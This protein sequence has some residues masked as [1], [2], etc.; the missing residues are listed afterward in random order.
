MASY[1][2]IVNPFDGKMTLVRADSAFHLKDSVDT[3]YDLPIINN[4]END[5]RIT[6]DTDLM[7]TW[8][9]AS[10]SGLIADWKQIGSASSVDWSAITN[11][12]SSSVVN[13]D[14]AVDKKHSHSNKTELDKVSDGDH[15]IRTDNPHEVDKSDVGLDNVDNKSEATI[16]TNVKADS[17]VSDAISKKHSQNT[18]TNIILTEVPADVSASGIKTTFTAGENLAFGEV[19]YQ[20]S[21]G[22]IWKADATTIATA[23]VVVMALASISAEASGSFLL[24]RIVRDDN[25][26]WTVGGN[27]YLHTTAGEISQTAPSGTDEA[28]IILGVATHEHR[29]LFSP[30]KTI[31]EHV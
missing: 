12:P 17:D 10:A 30:D 6:E 23:L 27:I 24:L 9:I 13:I 25:W 3:Y 11:K 31:I 19:C 5:V 7:Y 29:I 18:D 28:I 2:A 22:K 4:T 1:K 21:D 16:I 8:S 20:K 15:D 26:S 14:D